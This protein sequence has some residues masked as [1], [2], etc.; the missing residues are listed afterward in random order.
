MRVV[1][2]VTFLCQ[3][4]IKW[5]CLATLSLSEL[6]LVTGQH[7][8]GTASAIVLRACPGRCLHI[9]VHVSS[10]F[11]RR[12]CLDI[13][14]M[15]RHVT[16]RTEDRSLGRVVGDGE[17]DKCKIAYKKD[18]D[19]RTKYRSTCH[20]KYPATIAP[21]IQ[22]IIAASI[23]GYLHWSEKQ[24]AQLW[25]FTFNLEG[26]AQESRLCT[27]SLSRSM[28]NGDCEA[29]HLDRELLSRSEKLPTTNL[30]KHTTAPLADKP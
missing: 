25:H 13:S 3:E 22:I 9:F 10:A 15:P 6:K 11:K 18:V 20:K 21:M 16:G 17:V 12:A 30:P 1:A 7:V 14:T 23:C 29:A 4:Q 24:S 19:Q 26:A 5:R 8:A 28:L 2:H 27:T